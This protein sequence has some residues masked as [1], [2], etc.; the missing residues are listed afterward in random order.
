VRSVLV[1]AVDVPV[2]PAA[3]P[4]ATGLRG[5]RLSVD[6]DQ[7]DRPEPSCARKAGP[8]PNP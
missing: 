7:G 6:S 4:P 5:V 8:A 2:L 1:V 3:V